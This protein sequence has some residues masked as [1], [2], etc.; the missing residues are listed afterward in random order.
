MLTVTL[1]LPENSF[2][3]QRNPLSRFGIS[4]FR[5]G[6]MFSFPHMMENY[7]A[8]DGVG[9]FLNT[10][11]CTLKQFIIQII[12]EY[13]EFLEEIFWWLH[14]E[15][16]NRVRTSQSKW[17]K[18]VDVAPRWFNWKPN[19]SIRD[20]RALLFCAWQ[21]ESEGFEVENATTSSVFQISVENLRIGYH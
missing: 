10:A 17:S 20:P 11:K 3:S 12:V 7:D 9:R 19:T 1:K 15:I 5:R 14:I 6:T 21:T 8:I 16:F 13:V 2:S 18:H 4:N